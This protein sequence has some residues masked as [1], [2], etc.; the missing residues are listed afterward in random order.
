[1]LWN[2]AVEEHG[3]EF[4]E[5]NH[6]LFRAWGDQTSLLIENSSNEAKAWIFCI[7]SVEARNLR[8]IKGNQKGFKEIKHLVTIMII[9]L[10]EFK[11][12]LPSKFFSIGPWWI[13]S[14]WMIE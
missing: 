7:P 14:K 11:E 1:M 8:I 10:Q 9:R 12:A 5:W 3:W 4:I 13:R 6:K 2:F